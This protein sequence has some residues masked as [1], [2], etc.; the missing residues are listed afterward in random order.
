MRERIAALPP[1][2]R[3]V[4]DL[5]LNHELDHAAIGRLLGITPENSRA[6]YYQAVRKLR[7]VEDPPTTK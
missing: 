6:N 2:Q 7:A 3:E 4:L 5:R 1:R